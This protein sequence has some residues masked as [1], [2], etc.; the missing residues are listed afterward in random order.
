ME[1]FLEYS[2]LFWSFESIVKYSRFSFWPI[3]ALV[4]HDQGGRE[5][6]R[7]HRCIESLS[8]LITVIVVGWSIPQ[9]GF[10]R[11]QG[12][13]MWSHRPNCRH[14]G[15]RKQLVREQGEDRMAGGYN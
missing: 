10:I 8:R 7:Y 5:I 11:E 4:D 6:I 9:K 13:C 15:S 14:L 3:S 12:A 1:N 2:S